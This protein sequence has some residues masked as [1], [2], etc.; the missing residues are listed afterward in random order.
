MRTLLRPIFEY[1]KSQG[2]SNIGA[3]LTIIFFTLAIY[4]IVKKPDIS[5]DFLKINKNKKKGKH[6][7]YKCHSCEK[8]IPYGHTKCPYCGWSF[9]NKKEPPTKKFL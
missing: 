3:G 5:L 7:L 2:Y 9:L 8:G 4:Y 1:L 6:K